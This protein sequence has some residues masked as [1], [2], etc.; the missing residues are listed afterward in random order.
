MKQSAQREQRAHGCDPHNFVSYLCYDTLLPRLPEFLPRNEMD[1]ATSLLD[2]GNHALP[3][4]HWVCQGA[5]ATWRGALPLHLL[6]LSSQVA[7]LR[8]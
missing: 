6:G 2:G 4:L 5:G 8:V 3:A 1:G 7:I